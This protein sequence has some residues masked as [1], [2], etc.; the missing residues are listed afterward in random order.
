M[1]QT[2][3]IFVTL[4]ITVCSA[5]SQAKEKRLPFEMVS[6]V[7]GCDTIYTLPDKKAAFKGGISEMYD[8]F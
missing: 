1:K 4:F 3:L 8:F 7:A 2:F 6:G 5:F